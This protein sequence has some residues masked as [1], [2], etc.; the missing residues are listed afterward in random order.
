MYFMDKFIKQFFIVFAVMLMLGSGFLA[1]NDNLLF[2]QKVEA[3]EVRDISNLSTVEKTAVYVYRVISG[4]FGDEVVVETVIVD[5][6]N[7]NEF[8]DD[9]LQFTVYR[10]NRSE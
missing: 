9:S 3:D 5:N 4:F 8:T 10:P 6:S 2:L 7:Q 1:N